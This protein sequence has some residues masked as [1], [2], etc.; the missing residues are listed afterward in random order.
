M[1]NREAQ[2]T[3]ATAGYYNGGLDGIIGQKSRNAMQEIF[4]QLDT[5]PLAPWEVGVKHAVV[6]SAQ[7]VLNH[8]GYDAGEADGLDGHNT[9]EAMTALLHKLMTGEAEV[10]DRTALPDDTQVMVSSDVPKPSEVQEFYG[11]PEFGVPDRLMMIE[12]PFHM[13]IDYNLKQRTSKITVHELAGPSLEA[14]LIGTHDHYGARKWGE[15]GLDRYAGCYNKRKMRGGSSWSMHAYGCA[16]D[17]YAAPNGLRTRCPDALFCRK[18][19]Q[20]FLD[21]MESHGWLPAIRLWGADAMHFQRAT[22]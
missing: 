7:L 3:W 18:E 9:Q 4:T 5:R 19:Y 16:I 20:A 10:V 13:R 21:I 15:L 17:F 1:Q 22:L 14:A 6:A 8:F 2:I 11:D 12:L